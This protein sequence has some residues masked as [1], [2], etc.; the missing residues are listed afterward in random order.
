MEMENPYDRSTP[1]NSFETESNDVSWDPPFSDDE[2]MASSEEGQREEA[3]EDPEM[4]DSLSEDFVGSWNRLVSTTNWK[5]GEVI[6]EWRNRLVESGAPR[7][8]Y[9]D[10][11]W[12]RRVGNVTGQHVGRLRRVFERFGR[13][14]EHYPTLF[15]SHFQAAV[16]WNDAE[17]WLEGAV[18]NGWSVAVM[19]TKRWEAIGAPPEQKPRDEDIILSE[20]DEDVN[21]EEDSEQVLENNM[22]AVEDVESDEEDLSEEAFEDAEEPGTP[23]TAYSDL[24]ISDDLSGELDQLDELPPDLASSFEAM[25]IALLHHKVTEWKEVSPDRLVVLLEALKSL[26][27]STVRQ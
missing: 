20:L 15:W 7:Q 21:P 23:E 22:S 12:A 2:S 24:S 14:H 4:L 19:R 11:A 10:E 1:A 26:V 6:L 16:D 5:K 27:T 3:L 9:S 13:S 17:M 18:Q 25:K 8:S